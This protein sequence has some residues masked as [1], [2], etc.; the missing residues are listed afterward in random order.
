MSLDDSADP[1]RA[2][3]RELNMNYPVVLGDAA[4]AKQYGGILGL[5]VAFLI[6]CDGRIETRF[7]GETA[8][9]PIEKRLRSLLK[10]KECKQ[11]GFDGIPDRR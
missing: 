2:F 11:E 5:P 8:I 3:H 1:V 7:D 10:K 6:G 9:A 4:L